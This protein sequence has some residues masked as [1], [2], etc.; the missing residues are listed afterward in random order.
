MV[1]E[2]AGAPGR[3]VREAKAHHCGGEF[4]VSQLPRMEPHDRLGSYELEISGIIMA[5][6]W[7]NA[8]SC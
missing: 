1:E 2:P 4:Q 7:G 3:H 6:A 5:K 8:E